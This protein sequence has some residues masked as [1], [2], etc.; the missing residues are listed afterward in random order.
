L[1]ELCQMDWRAEDNPVTWANARAALEK[2]G[3]EL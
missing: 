2:A 3:V 1:K